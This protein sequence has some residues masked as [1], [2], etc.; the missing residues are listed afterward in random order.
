M[1]K[2]KIKKHEW[3]PDAPVST[4]PGKIREIFR[5]EAEY[6]YNDL[7][8]NRLDIDTMPAPQPQFSGHKIR[9]VLSRNPEWYHDLYHCMSR[10]RPY[11]E[12]S[13][14]R[15]ANLTDKAPKEYESKCGKTN[16]VKYKH[17]SNIRNFIFY[18][19]ADGHAE[20][21]ALCLPNKEIRKYFGLK[22][23]NEKKWLM[24]R[25]E[26]E[27]DLKYYKLE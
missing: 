10:Y 22:K 27:K 1:I 13:L 21:G 15:I 14:K 7:M 11:A 8:K 23:I 5:K 9:V 24:D 19:L 20:N 16:Y 18:R 4:L 26:K 6:L 17:N 25:G 12:N 2:N 3:N